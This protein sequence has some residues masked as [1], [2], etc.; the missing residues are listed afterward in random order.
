MALSLKYQCL[1]QYKQK[2]EDFNCY[3]DFID[4]TDN[5]L[6]SKIQVQKVKILNSFWPVCRS[7]LNTYTYI[8]LHPTKKGYAEKI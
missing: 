7:I 8:Y 1:Y 4:L 6:K 2:M 5:C 3:S